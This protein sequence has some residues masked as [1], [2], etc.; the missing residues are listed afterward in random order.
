M[1]N[2]GK[3]DPVGMGCV[4]FFPQFPHTFPAGVNLEI[5]ESCQGKHVLKHNLKVYEK[6]NPENKHIATPKS[7]A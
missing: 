6:Q 1:V 4:F 7:I 5:K 3:D 2:V